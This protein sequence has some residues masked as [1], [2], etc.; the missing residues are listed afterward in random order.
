MRP[1][2]QRFPAADCLGRSVV[3]AESKTVGFTRETLG[4]SAVFEF[5]LR[6]SG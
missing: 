1:G 3:R 5:G 6:A 2:K 4:C